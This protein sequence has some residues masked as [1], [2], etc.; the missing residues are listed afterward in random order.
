[1][2]YYDMDGRTTIDAGVASRDVARITR[3][4]EILST[5]KERV[6][7]FAMQAGQ[8]QGETASA[9]CE[10]AM[11]LSRSMADIISGCSL[12]AFFIQQTVAHY[13]HL[14]REVKETIGAF[15]GGSSGGGVR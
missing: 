1:M 4:E 5:A 7:A 2:P 8:M 13:E 3:A 15:G 12:T 14:D 6:D 11:E 10:K 9:I